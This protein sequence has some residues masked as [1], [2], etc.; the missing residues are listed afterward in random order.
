[1]PG[2]GRLGQVELGG[3]VGQDRQAAVAEGGQGPGGPAQLHGQ[4]VAVD[5]GQPAAG[6]VQADQPAGR[7][8]PEG[9]RDRLLEQGPP[10]HQGV[11]VGVGQGGAGVG[12]PRQVVQQRRQRPPGD[13]HGRRV[14]H[15]LAGRALVDVA[16]DLGREPVGELAD[17]RHHRVAGGRAQ[18][19]QL[20]RVE[21]AGLAGGG[22]RLGRPGRDQPGLGRGP[23][24]GGL[25]VQHG[26]EERPV[27]DLGGG[28][29]P[30]EHPAQQ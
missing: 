20:G 7:L 21:P 12:C 8:E 13:Q 3:Q 30:A 6:L 2:Q 9:H 25:D 29:P 26:L 18:L 15:V 22:D 27:P 14:E 19:A 28:P 1:M 16:G 24:Q 23:G 11:A 5:P 17:Q 4:L 10:G